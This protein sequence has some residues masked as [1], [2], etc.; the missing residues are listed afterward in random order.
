[1]CCTLIH[2]N[3]NGIQ[4]PAFMIDMITDHMTNLIAG[5]MAA[6]VETLHYAVAMAN[7]DV[8]GIATQMLAGNHKANA[9]EI[10]N[11]V[12]AMA[13]TEMQAA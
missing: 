2:M 10:R 5:G 7:A 6:D 13:Y 3:I 11:A 9:E 4:I 8:Q 12:A 1:M